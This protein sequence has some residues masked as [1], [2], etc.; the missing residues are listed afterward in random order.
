MNSN[1]AITVKDLS[2]RYRIGASKKDS[3]LESLAGFFDKV[4]RDQNESDFWALR[5]LNFEIQKGEAIGIIGKNGAG[6]S[7]LLKI[8]SRI[9]EPTTGRIEINGRVS[10]LLEVGT[11]FHPELTGKE[12]IYLNGTI[13]GMSRKEIKSKYDEIVD[14]SGVEKFL[15]TPV[16]HYSSG[17]YVRL[18]FAVAA[19]LE[20]EI[21]IIDEVLAVGDADFQKKCLGKM[22]DVASQG[23]TVLFV[24]H[25]MEAIKNLTKKA[26]LIQDGRLAMYD[27]TPKIIE[28]YISPDNQDNIQIEFSNKTSNKDIFLKSLRIQ[29]SESNG[30]QYWNGPIEFHFI[31]EIKKVM[32]NV[33]FSFQ[34]IDQDM[35]NI[36]YC[37]L[38]NS[39]FEIGSKPGPLS[40]VCTIKNCKLFQGKYSLKTWLTDRKSSQLLDHQSAIGNFEVRVDNIV[41]DEY[42]WQ[43]DHCRYLE[44]FEWKIQDKLKIQMPKSRL[45]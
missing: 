2:K 4:P 11:G 34:I 6:K 21:L 20:P 16:K 30:L 40:L 45:Q 26:L 9:T 22:K 17:M 13:L 10:S 8:L 19:H 37:W 27:S 7:T 29:T 25:N 23:R 32:S 33:C 28:K 3:L 1:V 15:N 44:H 41:H 39:D 12:N 24:S 18:A 35:S 5:D 43:K 42:H 14:F 38:F 36:G 31:I